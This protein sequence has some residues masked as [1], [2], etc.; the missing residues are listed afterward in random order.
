M[1]GRKN[2]YVYVVKEHLPLN[3]GG[4]QWEERGEGAS[5]EGTCGG[6]YK[7]GNSSH[8]ATDFRVLHECCGSIYSQQ[9]F[10]FS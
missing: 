1:N 5:W 3:G 2:E 8:V 7:G 9:R 4:G 6:V 10:S